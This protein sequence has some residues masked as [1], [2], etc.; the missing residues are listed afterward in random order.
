MSATGGAADAQA[1]RDTA[2]P[3]ARPTASSAG[4]SQR[5]AAQARRDTGPEMAIRR[6][7]FAVGFRYRVNY[8]VA[9]LGRC[10]VDIAFPARRVAVF[11]D[12]CFWH[13]CPRHGSVPAANGTWW[14]DKLRAN[15]RRDRAVTRLLRR[16]GWTVLR[17]WEHDDPDAAVAEIARTLAGPADTRKVGRKSAVTRAGGG[18]GR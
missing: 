15:R 2:G 17:F 1:V 7:L 13:A 3:R 18:G 5:M 9:G 12:G 16:E 14:R 11:V 10:S 4:V 8:R 6:R